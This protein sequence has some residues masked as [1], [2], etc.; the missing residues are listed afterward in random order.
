VGNEH[1]WRPTTGSIKS[2]HMVFA[3][4]Q[5]KLGAD[6]QRA[7]DRCEDLLTSTVFQLLRYLPPEAGMLPILSSMKRVSLKDGNVIAKQDSSWLLLDRINR[8]DVDFW[9]DIGERAEPDLRIRLFDDRE[10]V[11]HTVIVECKLY[12]PKSGRASE[13][14]A[15]PD[16]ESIDT[17]NGLKEREATRKILAS[18][19]KT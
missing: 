11:A 19:D 16:I 3:E 4:I 9:P 1:H 12:S 10:R 14:D 6:G 7:H 2:R 5:G 13:D 8:F 15:A 18:G 17:C